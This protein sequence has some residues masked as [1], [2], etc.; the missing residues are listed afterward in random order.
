MRLP[1][2]AELLPH[3]EGAGEDEGEDNLLYRF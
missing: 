1:I 2:D 3:D